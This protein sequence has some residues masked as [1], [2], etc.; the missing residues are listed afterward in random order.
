MKNW[1]IECDYSIDGVQYTVVTDKT[2]DIEGAKLVIN[3]T[4]YGIKVEILPVKTLTVNKLKMTTKFNFVKTQKLFLNGYQSWTTSH[5][6]SISD[7]E[8]GLKFLPKFIVNQF[9]LNCYG[10]FKITKSLNKKGNL[11]GFS[12]AY[13][14]EGDKYDFIG[15]LN[16]QTG[17]TIIRFD[18]KSNTITLE[19]D[20][21]GHFIDSY[22]LAFD[23]LLLLGSEDEVFDKYFELNH[24]SKPTC[25][26]K[27][28]YT[29]WYNYYQNIDEKTI[30]NDLNGMCTLPTKLDIFQID[31]GYEQYVGDWL[32]PDKQKF[33]NGMK[34]I[35]QSIKD[36]GFTPG[37]WLAPFVCETK[38]DVF[39]NHKD[40]LAR[41][42]NGEYVYC[43]CNWS[44]FYALDLFN[45][46]VRKYIKNCFDVM[47]KDWGFEL[48]KLD[49]L[50][51]ACI[52]PQLNRTRG[53]LMYDAMKFLRECVGDKLILGCGVPLAPAY[54]MVDFCRIGAD[55]TLDWN[56][57]WY[58]H[59]AHTERPSTK[60][61]ML[62]SIYRRQLNGRAFYNDT[63]VFIL[64]DNN[65]KLTK[66][67]KLALATVNGL[68]GG[69]LFASDNFGE[70]DKEKQEIHSK[71]CK[72]KNAEV[73]SIVQTKSDMTIAYVLD[74]KTEVLRY[75]L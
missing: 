12:Y 16:E 2:T 35:C 7:K 39:I 8:V 25:E 56:D 52:I 23:I 5:E 37:I 69:L 29:S 57:K 32:K 49:F 22:F 51:A 45:L 64:R 19:K 67:Q 34:T 33:P 46:E 62:N 6:R 71:I 11:H 14:R 66:G 72:L 40:W 63:D 74:G 30:L 21:A 4:D 47:I 38:S 48:F 3:N 68:F 44:G 27:T 18:A 31:D 10:D 9:G 43:G 41:Y 1:Q 50:Y 65:T 42:P 53:E 13:I 73:T 20:C 36:K 54:G 58:M 59:V 26:S 70:Y 28:G 61:T 17:Y 15:S 75:D 55:I 24:I 60:N